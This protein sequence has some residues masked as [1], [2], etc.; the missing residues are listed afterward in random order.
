MTDFM[1]KMHQIR[2]RLRWGAYSAPRP[3]SCILGLLLREGE[4]R[5]GERGG[6]GRGGDRSEGRGG[7]KAFP[8]FLFYETTTGF[9]IYIIPMQQTHKTIAIQFQAIC[10][11]H[12]LLQILEI[13]QANFDVLFMQRSIIMFVNAFPSVLW[14]CWLGDRKGI[15]PV[16]S[17]MLVCWWWRFVWSFARLIAPVVIT[18]FI[19]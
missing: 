10:H 9:Y 13:I 15:R 6:E 8:L 16:K 12:R 14:H 17:W 11:Q 2:F 19:L 5:G 3:P 1:D 7:R 18:T 4:R